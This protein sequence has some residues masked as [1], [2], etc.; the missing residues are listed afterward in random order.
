[1]TGQ[2]ETSSLED[3]RE[4]FRNLTIV[5]TLVAAINNNGYPT[6]K[7]SQLSQ[8][9]LERQQP[10]VDA[11][12]NSLVTLFLRDA[13]VIAALPYDPPQDS[14]E[15]TDSLHL[16]VMQEAS[17]LPTFQGHSG[18]TLDGL[19]PHDFG[20][21]D[22]EN[23]LGSMTQGEPGLDSGPARVLVADNGASHLANIDSWSYNLN[24]Q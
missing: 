5:T 4:R 9:T 14:S 8:S 20:D 17:Y 11:T 3:I 1:M 6:L 16:L 7:R 15:H 18:P 21:V 23:R 24:L 22:K 13:E 19:E 12:L 10:F 2:C